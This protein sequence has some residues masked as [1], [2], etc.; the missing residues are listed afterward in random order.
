MKELSRDGHS[1]DEEDRLHLPMQC[2]RQRTP[3]RKYRKRLPHQALTRPA[4]TGPTANFQM[5]Y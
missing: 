2:L 1:E 3:L 5:G 4:A